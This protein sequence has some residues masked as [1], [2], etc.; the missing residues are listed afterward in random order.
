MKKDNPEVKE[1]MKFKDLRNEILKTDRIIKS[2]KKQR[3]KLAKNL[4]KRCAHALVVESPESP[5]I[6]E[7]RCLICGLEEEGIIVTGR[8][9]PKNK[10][11]WGRWPADHYFNELDRRPKVYQFRDDWLKT[12]VLQSLAA[13]KKIKKLPKNFEKK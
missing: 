2:I 1:T 4:Q 6:P 9:C 12:R 11:I 5:L 10:T 3:E 7:R 13:L 8:K